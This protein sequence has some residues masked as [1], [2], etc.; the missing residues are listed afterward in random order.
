[1]PVNQKH[2]SKIVRILLFVLILSACKKQPGEGGFET[3]KGRLFVKNYDPTCMAI[4]TKRI[5]KDEWIL[6]LL[7]KGAYV[8]EIDKSYCPASLD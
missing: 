2:I 1:M 8:L 3:I 5:D 7:D 4:L 6:H